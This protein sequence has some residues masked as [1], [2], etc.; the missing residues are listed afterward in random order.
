MQGIIEPD[1][2]R[3]LHVHTTFSDGI[4][5]PEEMILAAIAM[6]MSAVGISDHSYTSFDE[7]YCIRSGIPAYRAEVERL[8]QKYRDQITVLCGIEQ[9]YYSDE[10]A[11][12][13]DYVIGS[14]HYLKFGNE[15]VPVDLDAGILFDA[16]E[17]YCG[18]DF[19]ALAETY[20]K[21]VS[22]VVNKTGATIIGHF[23]LISKFNELT[24]LFDEKHPRYV[25]AWRNAVDTLLLTGVPFE[26]NFG[27]ISRG[28]KTV[29]YPS[30][31]M[32]RYIRDRGGSFILSGDAH[33]ADTLCF[34]FK[35]FLAGNEE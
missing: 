3:D 27:A 31:E 23:D 28:K 24:P 26:V 34:G 19:Y 8:K 5:T 9:D 16:A 17:K 35:D 22:D 1:K 25:A 20:F 14:V 4:N 33:R 2:L 32:R 15:Y 10:P 13:F 7:S 12:G 30:S 29:P 21:T 11:A 6:G 18:G